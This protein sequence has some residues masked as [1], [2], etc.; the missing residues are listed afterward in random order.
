VLFLQAAVEDLPEELNGIASEVTVQFPWGS[1]LRGVAGADEGVLSNLRRVCLPTAQLS[2]I[3]A[4]NP[5]RDHFEWERLGLEMISLDYLERVLAARY[6]QAGFR[7]LRAK[8]LSATDLSQLH[9]SWAR[10]LH[11]SPS[12]SFLGIVAEAVEA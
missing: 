4:L 12:R 5:E 10:R 7:I 2:V 11:Q 1:L 8:E 6:R 3:L 9:T